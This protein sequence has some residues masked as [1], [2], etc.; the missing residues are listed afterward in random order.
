[1]LEVY[2]NS[3]SVFPVYY[4]VGQGLRNIN[5]AKEDL[6]WIIKNKS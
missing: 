2:G 5:K 6:S 3:F 1:M 4:P